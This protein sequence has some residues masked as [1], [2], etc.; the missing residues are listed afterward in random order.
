[1]DRKTDKQAGKEIRNTDTG[2]QMG[3]RKGDFTGWSDGWKVSVLGGEGGGCND[4]H[5]NDEDD[6]FLANTVVVEAVVVMI[7]MMMMMM[8]MMMVVVV[9]MMMMT[10]ILITMIMMMTEHSVASLRCKCKKKKVKEEKKSLIIGPMLR[11]RSR[12][13]APFVVPQIFVDYGSR[14]TSY[15]SASDHM[16]LGAL[17][18]DLRRSSG[19]SAGSRR[20][21]LASDSDSSSTQACPRQI[22]LSGKTTERDIFSDIPGL[23]TEKSTRVLPLVAVLL[24]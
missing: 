7:T 20:T 16:M 18:L 21:S 23:V 4:G 17:A 14:R 2:K 24:S 19:S 8:M 9:V 5:G 15:A 13:E 22:D 1:M 6:D 10:L 11:K 12:D 3:E